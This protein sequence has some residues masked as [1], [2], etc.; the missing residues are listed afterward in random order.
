MS[1]ARF[2]SGLLGR[3]RIIEP[4]RDPILDSVYNLVLFNRYISYK[5]VLK[6]T[7]YLI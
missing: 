7:V 4:T 5:F 6:D 2:A 3:C 1:E